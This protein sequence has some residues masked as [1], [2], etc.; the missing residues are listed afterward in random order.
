MYN[1]ELQAAE[2]K[3]VD[4]EPTMVGKMAREA[5]QLKRCLPGLLPSDWICEIAAVGVFA[6]PRVPFLGS[7]LKSSK[8]PYGRLEDQVNVVVGEQVLRV[9][10]CLL[11]SWNRITQHFLELL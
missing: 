11:D 1:T 3:G 6:S 7:S 2:D 4:P 9:N 8:N 5:A 10:L